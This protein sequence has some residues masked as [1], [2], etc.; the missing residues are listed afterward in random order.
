MLGARE[1]R[2]RALLAL[3]EGRHEDAVVD[4]FRALTV[5]QVE[6]GAL[7]DA[8]GTTAHEVAA[9]LAADRPRHAAALRST[10][11]LFDRVLYGGRAASRADAEV[12]LDLDDALGR[13]E[14][15]S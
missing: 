15:S 5:R 10:A 11:A 3:A 4:G 8:P 9:T 13:A 1:L 14:V 7:P 2:E 6:S 12:V